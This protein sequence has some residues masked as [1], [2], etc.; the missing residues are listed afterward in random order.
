MRRIWNPISQPKKKQR[1]E[2]FRNVNKS[3]LRIS[4]TLSHPGGKEICHLS[5]FKSLKNVPQKLDMIAYHDSSECA[6]SR[7]AY[8]IKANYRD[9]LDGRL[10]SRENSSHGDFNFVNGVSTLNRR[11]DMMLRFVNAHSGFVRLSDFPGWK[12]RH[13]GWTNIKNEKEGSKH[14]QRI[15]CAGETTSIHGKRQAYHIVMNLITHWSLYW[16]QISRENDCCWIVTFIVVGRRNRILRFMLKI[17][18]HND[19][20]LWMPNLFRVFYFASIAD[21]YSGK[22]E[23]N[24][25]EFL[26]HPLTWMCVVRTFW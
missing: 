12:T 8:R 26:S 20:A 25:Y 14:S 3:F 6:L 10:S 21:L 2:T 13:S 16:A 11:L 9:M 4:W 7:F 18:L 22:E 19:N 17:F 23:R 1:L 5:Y 24:P 15:L